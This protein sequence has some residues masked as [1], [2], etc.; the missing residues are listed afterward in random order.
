MKKE[1]ITWILFIV[2]A[3]VL[4]SQ[5]QTTQSLMALSFN[6][7]SGWWTNLGDGERSVAYI[8]AGILFMTVIVQVWWKD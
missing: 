5:G 3:I 4:F 6:D 7:V 1:T 2:L 8:V